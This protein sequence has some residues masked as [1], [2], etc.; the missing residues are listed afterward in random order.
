MKKIFLLSIAL[1]SLCGAGIGQAQTSG[2]S[3]V[4]EKLHTLPTG[5]A[6]IPAMETLFQKDGKFF[7]ANLESKLP[8]YTGDKKTGA[9]QLRNA[10]RLIDKFLIRIG[11]PIA[12][13]LIAYAGIELLS[14]QGK[15]ETH[16]Q[17]ITQ[18][19]AIAIGF[20][21]MLSAAHLV[22]WVVFGNEGDIFRDKDGAGNAIDP[23]AFAKRGVT[24]LEGLF[25]F[26]TTFAVIIAVAYIIFNAMTM[27]LAAG[28]NESELA[29]AKKRIV[30]GITGMAILI[31]IKPM[32]DLFTESDGKLAVG[33][34]HLTIDLIAKWANYILGLLGVFAVIGLIYAGIRLI[35]NFG[36][37]A[38]M[39]N[40]KKIMIACGIGL[41]VAFSAWTVVNHFAT[42][43]G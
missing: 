33:N 29:G 26:L 42:P 34:I 1:I 17:K 43:A 8:D 7:D 15:E 5:A 11:I 23:A 25:H 2:I 38:A 4:T 41:L 13:L 16:S 39:E 31:S 32:R 40:A 21:L 37:E 28:E 27:I 9:E 19:L 30:F 24:E 14:A 12:I 3:S 22:D 18:L 35:S 20:L 10:V 6:S 36:D